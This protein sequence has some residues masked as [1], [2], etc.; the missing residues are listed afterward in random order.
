MPISS[1]SL[2]LA[3]PNTVFCINIWILRH[4]TQMMQE[5]QPCYKAMKPLIFCGRTLLSPKVVIPIGHRNFL[6]WHLE[7]SSF[8]EKFYANNPPSIEDLK[9]IIVIGWRIHSA[10]WLYFSLNIKITPLIGRHYITLIH[11][12]T[13]S[14]FNWIYSFI[15]F[16]KSCLFI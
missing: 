14:F 9:K 10:I 13:T 3:I 15:N 6:I 16:W 11:N 7:T 12:D 5:L 1:S 4:E 8:R 2:E